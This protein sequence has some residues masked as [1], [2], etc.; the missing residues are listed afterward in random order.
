M[1]FKNKKHNKN[2]HTNKNNSITA[3]ILA[4]G[5]T[6]LKIIYIGIKAEH[7]DNQPSHSKM[8]VLKLVEPLTS[9]RSST[10]WYDRRKKNSCIWQQC[11]HCLL[12]VTFCKNVAMLIKRRCQGWTGLLDKEMYHSVPVMLMNVF[13]G[14]TWVFL[15]ISYFIPIFGAQ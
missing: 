6:I 11:D 15:S 5:S 13:G 12:A 14:S 1:E 3:R 8:E 10:A 9:P 2:K 4:E 7:Q